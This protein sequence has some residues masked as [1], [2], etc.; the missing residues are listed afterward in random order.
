MCKR[1]ASDFIA[2]ARNEGGKGVQRPIVCQNCRRRRRRF[3][4]IH[5]SSCTN[6][7]QRNRS[8]SLQPPPSPPPLSIGPIMQSWGAVNLHMSNF[9][10]NL[11][12]FIQM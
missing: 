8:R 3:F 1:T 12:L 10:S 6:L 5:R 2:A 11:L 9:S 4:L 7:L